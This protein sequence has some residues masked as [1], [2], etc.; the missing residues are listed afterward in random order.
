MEGYALRFEV[1]GEDAGLG[2][3]TDRV[4]RRVVVGH[5]PGAVEGLEN[6]AEA[7][8]AE[9]SANFSGLAIG[10]E[11]PDPDQVMIGGAGR[12]R[13]YGA[14]LAKESSSDTDGQGRTEEG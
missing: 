6:D 14:A 2:W 5:P 13:L 8:G 11:L 7:V 1:V 3:V 12:V 9:E 10:C 4:G